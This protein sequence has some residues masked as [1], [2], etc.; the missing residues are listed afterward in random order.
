MYFFTSLEVRYMLFLDRIKKFLGRRPRKNVQNWYLR[1]LE[2]AKEKKE[3][4]AVRYFNRAIRGVQ[5]FRWD[6]EKEI[7]EG[8]KAFDSFLE[9]H[10]NDHISWRSKGELLNVLERYEEALECFEKAITVKPNDPR[11]WRNKGLTLFAL[12]EFEEA[13]NSFDKALS[14]DP[15]DTQSQIEK[16]N[17]LSATGD[18]LGAID[19][20]DIAMKNKNLQTVDG[21]AIQKQTDLIEK[22]ISGRIQL[23]KKESWRNPK[24]VEDIIRS[25]HPLFLGRNIK[26]LFLIKPPLE[27]WRQPTW[28]KSLRKEIP[29]KLSI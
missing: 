28:V 20:L 19:S 4:D 2:A 10:D 26:F 9:K 22:Q 27:S 23:K 7:E 1:G 3:E 17:I 25:G 6:D 15:N 16:G 24:S 8:L 12:H 14:L 18:H 13:I 11:S 21:E 5:A 29:P